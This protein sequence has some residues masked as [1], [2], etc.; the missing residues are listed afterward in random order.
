MEFKDRI[1]FLRQSN[2]LS[3]AEIA[4]QFGK[5]ES[6]IRSWELG[7]TKPDADTL[8]KLSAYFDC[9]VDYLLGLSAHVDKDDFQT[10][11]SETNRLTQNIVKL[12]SGYADAALSWLNGCIEIITE[13]PISNH[14]N[15]EIHIAWVRLLEAFFEMCNDA[16]KLVS[17]LEEGEV[18]IEERSVFVDFDITTLLKFARSRTTSVDII[19]C[20]YFELT[21]VILRSI[22]DEDVREKIMYRLRP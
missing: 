14:K 8:I 17:L 7:R 5:T 13:P 11:V 9:T 12:E 21:D 6:A 15:E 19:D 3:H 2:A 4:A 20:L 16:C 1:K 22:E 18:I 10:A